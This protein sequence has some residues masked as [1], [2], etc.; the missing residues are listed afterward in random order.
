MTALVWQPALSGALHDAI[1][2]GD[3]ERV[4]AEIAHGAVR[5]LV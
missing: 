1:V 3:V 4:K 5:S 2:N